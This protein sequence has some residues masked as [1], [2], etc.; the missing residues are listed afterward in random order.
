MASDVLVVDDD[1]AV[2]ISVG[3]VLEDEGHT[4]RTAASSAEAL[5]KVRGRVPQLVL[6][7]L[8]LGPDDPGGMSTLSVL[9]ERYPHLPVVLFS[10]E[11]PVGF[12]DEAVR[13]GAYDYLEKPFR[14][15]R[16]L[17]TVDRAV[18]AARLRSE[19]RERRQRDGRCLAALGPS[20]AVTALVSQIDRFA[21]SNARVLL[22]GPAGTARESLAR[23]IHERSHRARGPFVPLSIAAM[24]VDRIGVELFGDERGTNGPRSVGA[25]ERAHGGT[26]FVDEIASLPYALQIEL[27]RALVRGRI[28]RVGG[29][30]P[31]VVDARLV[32]ST[33]FDLERMIAED[34][35][36]RDLY[37]RAAVAEIVVPTLDQRVEDVP[38]LIEEIAERTSR[39][40][41]IP[42]PTFD[43]ALVSLFQ[44]HEW[45]GDLLQLRA[46]VEQTLVENAGRA[47]TIGIADLPEGVRAVFPRTSGDAGRDVLS[48][49]LREARETFEREYLVAQL[50][51][52]GWKIAKVARV[53]GMERS[54]LHRK[55]RSLGVREQCPAPCGDGDAPTT[56]RVE[57]AVAA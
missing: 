50:N 4:V 52:H 19:A 10:G 8:G 20:K 24:P 49:P 37:D 32:T 1:E 18:E 6:M 38:M 30:T 25:M 55:M 12:A 21:P 48:M 33:S 35:F 44:S 43:D 54:A 15:D 14:I 9:R 16:L 3:D 51:L 13:A 34:D 28:V 46:A 56:E 57:E 40:H 7:D 36:S 23:R 26:L 27:C 29:G 5:E 2:R 41:G 11:G 22:K 39:L 47:D 45:V 17:A 31:V 53:I 42:T